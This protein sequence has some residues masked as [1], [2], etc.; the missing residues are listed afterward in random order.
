M[1]TDEE[2]EAE[3][4]EVYAQ[5]PDTPMV[6]LDE[7]FAFCRREMSQRNCPDLMLAAKRDRRTLVQPRAGVAN[8]E[9][10]RVLLEFL[11]DAGSD[12]LPITIDSM[13]RTHRFDH[14]SRAAL[15]STPTRS[16]L[17]GYPLIHHGVAATRR[18]LLESERPV[19][20]RANSTDLRLVADVGFACG[21]SGFVSG[22]IYSTVQYSKTTSLGEAIRNWQYVYRLIGKYSEA[23]VPIMDDALGLTQSASCSV[24]ALM[25]AGVVLEALIMA[26]QGVKHVLAYAISQGT[27]AQDIAACLA[28]Q[29]LT[30]D[31]LAR[32]GFEDV[33]VYMTGN[34]FA[35]AFPPDEA[36]AFGLISANT[37]VAAM[38]RATLLYV[39]S[40]E[41]GF[42]VPTAEGNA[43]S[44]RST[45]YLLHLLAGQDFGVHSEE[46]EFER[47]LNLLEGRAILDAVLDLGGGDPVHGAIRAF[48]AGVLDEP[49][50]PSKV[51][52]G[53]VLVVR[54]ARGAVR[55]LDP[56]NV[57]IPPEARRLERERLEERGRR[58]GAALGYD[59]I[60][61]DIDYITGSAVL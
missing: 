20:L 40:I 3:R 36:A 13:T 61:A 39:K 59:D 11:E 47:E 44:V 35:G 54:D 52:H 45:R 37:L 29:E 57:P 9:G 50:A 21:M 43:A 27:I 30:E 23:G 33:N 60:V 19:H 53:D 8:I 24:P 49:A 25:H 12:I 42:G 46:V 17:N 31:Y 15:E 51:A 28:V 5:S 16:L 6:D 38:S 14:A 56:G 7:A 2:L 48:E 55:F 18:L 32:L 41:E 22:P 4:E 10:Q 26:A 58:K 1:L 34:H